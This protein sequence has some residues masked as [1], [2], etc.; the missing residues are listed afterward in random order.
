VALA[1]DA[2]RCFADGGERRD[3]K[4]VKGGAGSDIGPELFGS[5]AE[6]IVGEGAELGLKRVDGFDLRAVRLQTTVVGGAKNLAGDCAET[7][8]ATILGTSG[9]NRRLRPS[10]IV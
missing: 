10:A 2:A 5:G 8:H 9:L 1:K 3:Q 7:G 4:I 6:L